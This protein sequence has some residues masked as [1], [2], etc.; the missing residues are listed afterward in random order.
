[1]WYSN[2][3][4]YNASNSAVNLTINGK[5]AISVI[6]NKHRENKPVIIDPQLIVGCNGYFRGTFTDINIWNR[7]LTL[8]EIDVYTQGCKPSSSLQPSI[9]EW[10]QLNVSYQGNNVKNTT[11]PKAQ[12]CPEHG[13]EESLSELKILGY[14]MNF[15]KA[16]NLCYVIGGKMPLPKRNSSLL[17]E[18]I[19]SDLPT[20]CNGQ[21]WIP[22]VQSEITNSL[23]VYAHKVD[24]QQEVSDLPWAYGQPNG[25]HT[26]L[27]SAAKYHYFEMH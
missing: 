22:I 24:N 2:C 25:K 17:Y 26:V 23:W 6:D 20:H 3:I 4:I 1:M 7:P 8:Q 14:K 11:I 13:T 19:I 9:L 10:P 21:F 18:H 27:V 15:Y 5:H 12:L 16:L